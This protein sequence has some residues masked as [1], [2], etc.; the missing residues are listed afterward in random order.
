MNAP[1]PGRPSPWGAWWLA[2]RPRTMPLAITPVLVGTSLAWHETGGFQPGP[3]L[4]ALLAAALIQAGTNLHNDAGD[5]ARG[6][7]TPDRLGP[8]R[9]TAEGWLTLRQVTTGAYLCFGIALLVG[10]YLA[11]VGGWPI[12]ALGIASLAAGLAYTGGIRPIAYSALG[13]LFVFLFFGLAAVGGSYYLQTGRVSAASLLAGAALGLLAAAVLVVN[14][15]RDFDTDRRAGKR[16]LAVVV[17]R[18]GAQRL[19]VWMLAL[20]FPAALAVTDTPWVWAV[21]LT[22]PSAFNLVR[23]F[24]RESPGPVFNGILAA[25]ARLQLHFGLLFSLGLLLP[26]W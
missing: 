4:A 24:Q 21:G 13:E 25:T 17:G 20:P 22:A 11:R 7:D 6:A 26:R 9:A 1:L 19:Y 8:R 10:I 18:E 16:T 12:V 2:I 15:Y 14:N 3:L 5:F 23:C